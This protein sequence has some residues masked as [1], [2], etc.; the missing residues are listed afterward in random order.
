M[1]P[2]IRL[3]TDLGSV[4]ERSRRR[5]V[6]WWREL[7]LVAG[8]YAV[9]DSIRGVIAGSI[10]RAQSDAA[11]LLR[12]ERWTHLDPEH[13]LNNALQ[14]VGVLAVP[15]CYFYATLHFVVTPA[16]LIWIYKARPGAYRHA[17]TVLA[18]VT[19]SALLGFWRFPTAPPRLLTAGGFHD[20][21][22]GYSQWGWW[23]SDASVPAGAAAIANQF[24]AMPSLHMAWAVWCGVTVY[25]LASRRWLRILAVAYP[26]LTALV[27]LGT[28]N[29][30][31]ADVLA[32]AGL[33]VLA[34]FGVRHVARSAPTPDQDA[35]EE[36]S[37]Q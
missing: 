26:V 18:V 33:W 9:Y 11:E 21:L 30:F 6:R 10:P 5:P 14:H 29:H 23:G 36:A 13:G 4:T 1:R 25:R 7:I 34:D 20:T 37:L 31:L 22:A 15:A 2:Q 17:R 28:A 8:F 3:S 12:W 32:G 24:A 19:A 35:V 27:V 16:V